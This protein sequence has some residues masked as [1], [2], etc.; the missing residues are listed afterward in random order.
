MEFANVVSEIMKNNFSLDR[1]V[2]IFVLTD[3]ST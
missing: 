3:N 1:D 2:T